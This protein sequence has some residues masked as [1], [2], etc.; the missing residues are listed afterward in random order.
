MNLDVVEDGTV[1]FG[2]SRDRGA[3]IPIEERDAGPGLDL[4]AAVAID[5]KAHERAT[6]R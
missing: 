5:L 6:R 3:S 4:Q 2:G 1:K